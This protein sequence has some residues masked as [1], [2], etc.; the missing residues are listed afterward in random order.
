MAV[1]LT[2]KLKKIF[3]FWRDRTLPHFALSIIQR[4]AQCIPQARSIQAALQDN[5]LIAPGSSGTFG[6]L[7]FSH[8]LVHRIDG[9][10]D[11]NAKLTHRMLMLLES[12]PFDAPE[13]IGH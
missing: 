13:E 4:A 3:D 5:N 8:D 10:A 9:G 11:S 12:R 1:K 7:V 2:S 6:N